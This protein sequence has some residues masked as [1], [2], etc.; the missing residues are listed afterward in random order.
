[1]LSGGLRRPANGSGCLPGELYARLSF[2]VLY[3]II[4]H[5]FDLFDVTKRVSGLH[6]DLDLFHFT[7]DKKKCYGSTFIIK[8]QLLIIYIKDVEK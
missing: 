5:M 8:I 4:S 7:W 6:S 3:I 1:M 2:D